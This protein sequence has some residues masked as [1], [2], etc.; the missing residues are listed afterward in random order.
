MQNLYEI[1]GVDREASAEAI[2]EAAE[3]LTRQASA[4][5]NTAPERSQQLRE[6]VRGAK[7]R[8]LAGQE[9]RLHYDEELKRH[10]EE[11][12]AKG[13]ALEATKRPL[14][15]LDPQ[16]RAAAQNAGRFFAAGLYTAKASRFGAEVEQQRPNTMFPAP[17]RMERSP[18]GPVRSQEPHQFVPTPGAPMPNQPA[19]E[20][21]RA[22]WRI[23]EG[24]P[25][26]PVRLWA[27]IT[28]LGI[29]GALSAGWALYWGVQVAPTLL[30]GGLATELSSF[31]LVLLAVPFIFGIGSI[32][33]ARRLQALDRVA[34]ILA[35]A[36][37]LSAGLAFLL[38]DVR[39]ALLV[40]VA[41]ACVGLALFLL[42]DPVVKS[43]FKGADLEPAPIVAARVLSVLVAC[44]MFLVGVMFLPLTPLDGALA[45]EGL[46]L[47]GLALLVFWLS[48]GLKRGDS[49]ARVLITGLGVAYLVLSLIA[50]HGQP[51]VILPVGLA[52]CV[53]GLLWLPRSSRSYYAARPRPKST[54]VAAMERAFMW[55][56]SALMAAVDARSGAVMEEVLAEQATRVSS[57]AIL[58]H[59]G[60][61]PALDDQGLDLVDG[62]RPV[63][64]AAARGVAADG[65]TNGDDH[66]E[67]KQQLCVRGHAVPDGLAW[68]RQCGAPVSRKAAYQRH[69]QGLSSGL[70]REPEA[71]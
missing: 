9:E 59:I 58:H 35:I 22:A 28:V 23:P 34:R 8:L 14:T 40:V 70:D 53:I 41:L 44:A 61:A 4:L 6:H 62:A 39:D 27:V 54:A 3:R 56:A 65:L 5:A 38:T 47:M 10:E 45:I 63:P 30:D 2:T 37:C 69:A 12:R 52:I 11:E 43:H 46:L 49:A 16:L 71:T 29:V 67:T 25:G 21:L 66:P 13:E 42:L 31:V 7:E 24:T 1:L 26:A 64:R 20:R 55:V 50:G 60:E 33:M 18:T 51:G 32:Y 48:R 36:L 17:Q 68:C 15:L 19:S 57:A